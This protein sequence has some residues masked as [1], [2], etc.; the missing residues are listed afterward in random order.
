VIPAHFPRMVAAELRVVFGRASGRLALGVALAVGLLAVALMYAAHEYGGS[1]QANGTPVSSLVSFSAADCASWALRGR[2]FFVLPLVLLLAG[3]SALGGELADHTAREL[4]VRPVSR[5][6]VVL[7]KLAALA[8]LSLAT[9][10]AT[11]V[12]A[13]VGGGAL[14]GFTGDL[15][16]QLMLGYLASWGRDL[17]LL[18]LVFLCSTFVT[19][20]G[21]AVVVV[22]LFLFADFGARMLLKLLGVMGVAGAE[23]I[24]QFLPGAALDA[25]EHWNTGWMWEPFL[26][27]FVLTAVAIAAT[28]ARVNRMDVA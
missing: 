20:V 28:I 19:S 25:W 14:F 8:V 2:N 7:A 12:P 27:L 1:A 18:S 11:F 5:P 15:L 24:G 9:L 13:L 26:G 4:L 21:T 23:T 10:G 16:P 22:V 3:A 6:S 17:G